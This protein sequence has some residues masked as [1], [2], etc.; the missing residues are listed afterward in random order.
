MELC[1]NVILGGLAGDAS[2]YPIFD[3]TIDPM[4][5]KE[6]FNQGSSSPYSRVRKGVS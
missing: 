5:H 1:C 4:P 6:L 2:C 3:F